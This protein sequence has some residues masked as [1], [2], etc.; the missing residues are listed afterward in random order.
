[1]PYEVMDKIEALGDDEIAA[2]KRKYESIPTDPDVR[3][4]EWD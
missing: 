1:M 3:S 4:S 2:A